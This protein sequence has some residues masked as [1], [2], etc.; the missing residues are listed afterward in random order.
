SSDNKENSLQHIKEQVH[1]RNVRSKYSHMA[2][3]NFKHR[4]THPNHIRET[5]ENKQLKEKEPLKE[6]DRISQTETFPLLNS[7]LKEIIER[8]K[9]LEDSKG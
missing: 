3:D 5:K 1:V 9:R 7:A 8:L 6:K 4:Y 2:E